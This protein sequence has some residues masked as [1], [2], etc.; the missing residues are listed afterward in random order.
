MNRSAG[1][2]YKQAL[3][4]PPR[5]PASAQ[6][7]S[8]FVVIPSRRHRG[9][10]AEPPGVQGGKA[11]PCTPGEPAPRASLR[12]R[13]DD[14][15]ATGA[16][17]SANP[18]HNQQT[19]PASN[20]LSNYG[21]VQTGNHPPR[22]GPGRRSI[23]THGRQPGLLHTEEVRARIGRPTGVGSEEPGRSPATQDRGLRWAASTK[24]PSAIRPTTA[25]P[26]C[27]ARRV[28]PSQTACKVTATA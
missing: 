27:I 1:V 18:E 21:G 14:T 13:G 7:W 23:R 9:L 16:A 4:A 3:G 17:G 15:Q 24:P 2:P 10:S 25:T 12:T 28:E 6:R 26:T 5:T 20:Q 19:R 11:L 22:R 8:G